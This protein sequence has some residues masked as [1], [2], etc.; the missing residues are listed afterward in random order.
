MHSPPS[1]SPGE[2][3]VA[4]SPL[5]GV[6]VKFSRYLRVVR[7]AV[8]ALR[9]PAIALS[10]SIVAM[11]LMTVVLLLPAPAA[12]ASPAQ[13]IVEKCA[14]G[15][16]FSGYSQKDYREALKQLTTLEIEYSPCPNLI[17]KD[18][19]V[20][21]GGGGGGVTPAGVSPTVA[22]PLTPTEQ[23]AVQRAHHHGSAPVRVGGEPVSPGVVHADIASAV[24]TLPDS[25]F[26]VLALMFAGAVALA[27]R[28]GIKRVRTRRD[29]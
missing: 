7:S 1:A 17:R 29:G 22:L 21:A 6:S 24:N 26:A 2:R 8:R 27:T 9:R 23:R 28:E 15:E 14:K 20:A 5:E 16:P 12:V 13:A 4:L 3:E 11:A 19:A 18:A 10:R 25:L